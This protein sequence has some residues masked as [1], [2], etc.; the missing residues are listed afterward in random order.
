MKKTWLLLGLVTLA[1]FLIWRY[2]ASVITLDNLKLYRASLEQFVA[3]HYYASVL[4]YILLY[5]LLVAIAFPTAAVLTLTGGFLFGTFFGALYALIG[6][7]IGATLLFLFI[8]YFIGDFFQQTY[9]EQLKSFN[10]TIATQGGYYLIALRLIAVIP[11]FLVT[12]LAG[13]SSLSLSAFVT[14]TFIGIIPGCLVYAYAGQQLATI[15]SMRDI[16]S[17]PVLLAFL[18]LAL[19]AL[20]PLFLKKTLAYRSS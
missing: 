16:L 4:G 5:T 6:A 20:I 12:I 2:T 3:D 18:F 17:L 11:F 10:M 19:L 1:L 13:L 9:K 14:S 8:R 15:E 7:T